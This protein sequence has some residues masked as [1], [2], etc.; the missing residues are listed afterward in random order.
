MIEHTFDENIPELEEQLRW[1]FQKVQPRENFIEKLKVRLTVPPEIEI[2]PA[3][4]YRSGGI[5]FVLLALGLFGGGLIYWL[6]YRLLR[7]K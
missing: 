7:K 1:S 2:D 6:L 3:P 5:L 4:N